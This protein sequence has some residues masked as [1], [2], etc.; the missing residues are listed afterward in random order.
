M[1]ALVR[2]EETDEV[3]SSQLWWAARTLMGYPKD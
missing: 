1:T 2:Y 3:E